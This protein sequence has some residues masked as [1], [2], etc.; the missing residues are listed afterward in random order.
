MKSN[1]SHRRLPPGPTDALPGSEEKI[2]VLA[3]RAR[4]GLPLWHPLDARLPG[5][6]VAPGAPAAREGC[7]AASA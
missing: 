2:R 4:L 6:Q 1:S 7:L 3:E 5:A